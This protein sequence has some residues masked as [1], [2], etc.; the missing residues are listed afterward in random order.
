MSVF[1]KPVAVLTT[2]LAVIAAHTATASASTAPEPGLVGN[3]S[4]NAAA[5]PAGEPGPYR[6][7]NQSTLRCLDVN[8]N[9]FVQVQPCD[10]SDRGQ[11]WIIWNGGWVKNQFTGKCLAKWDMRNMFTETCANSTHQYWQFWTPQWFQN[12]YSNECLRD[13]NESD[14]AA[15]TAGCVHYTQ[16]YWDVRIWP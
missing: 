11:R 15:T 2:L 8:E 9:D 1:T 6:I 14:R 10:S 4:L 3:S 13:F 12:I 7:Q 16:Y 5:S